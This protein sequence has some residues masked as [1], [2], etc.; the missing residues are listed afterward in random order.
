[1]VPPD[2]P[3]IAVIHDCIGSAY[4]PIKENHDDLYGVPTLEELGE[5]GKKT[6]SLKKK[7]KHTPIRYTVNSIGVPKGLLLGNLAW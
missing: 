1:M 6:F 4:T 7:K 3:A 2:P 5:C